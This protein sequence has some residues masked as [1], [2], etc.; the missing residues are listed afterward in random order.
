MPC[1]FQGGSDTASPQ[2]TTMGGQA[3]PPP[4]VAGLMGPHPGTG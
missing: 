2:E 3:E 4:Q 1:W